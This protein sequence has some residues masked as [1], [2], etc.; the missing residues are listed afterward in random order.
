[1]KNNKTVRREETRFRRQSSNLPFKKYV[2]FYTSDFDDDRQIFCII[3][4]QNCI[5]QKSI[6]KNGGQNKAKAMY[7]AMD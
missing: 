3:I 7:L 6:P 2:P 5:W 4:K 1:M